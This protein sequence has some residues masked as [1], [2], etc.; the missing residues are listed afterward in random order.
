MEFIRIEGF[1]YTSFNYVQ[2]IVLLVALACGAVLFKLIMDK[3]K[4]G[5]KVWYKDK[6]PAKLYPDVKKG[7]VDKKAG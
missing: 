1:D 3:K 2:V 4:A 7:Y 6:I 5:K